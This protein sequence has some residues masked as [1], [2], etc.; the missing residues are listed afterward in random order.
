[1]SSVIVILS[2][3]E[4]VKYGNRK[5]GRRPFADM[6]ESISETI[7]E[8]LIGLLVEVRIGDKLIFFRG[9]HRG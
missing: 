3:L 9:S 6:T 5:I 8:E 1:M 2:L 4:G 7:F